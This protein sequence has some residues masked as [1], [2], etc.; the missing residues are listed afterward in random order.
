M[1]AAL[2][3]SK[4]LFQHRPQ[5]YNGRARGT[6]Y[7]AWP[8]LGLCQDKTRECTYKANV[9]LL[10]FRL[11]WP[12]IVSKVWRER[13]PTRCNNQMFIINF[14]LNM[15]RASLWPASGLQRPC[16]AA[17][18]VLRWFCWMWLVTVVGRCFVG[19]EHSNLHSA[20]ILQRSAPQPLRTTSSRT[21]AVHHMQ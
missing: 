17:Y 7:I 19:C 12:C 14:C 6:D 1:A 4:P 10:C 13:K 16:V 8:S 21:S 11:L 5:S 20:H 18:G 15:F 3:P 2:S 9:I